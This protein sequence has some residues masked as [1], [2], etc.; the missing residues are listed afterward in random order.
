MRTL[1]VLLDGLTPC[2]S[3]RTA[4]GIRK[5][6][7]VE[8]PSNGRGLVSLPG[9]GLGERR[10]GAREGTHFPINHKAALENELN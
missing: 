7:D 2:S 3:P 6:E 1:A 4:L 8:I 5:K 9:G 10:S